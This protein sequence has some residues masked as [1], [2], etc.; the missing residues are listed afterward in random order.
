MKDD[1]VYYVSEHRRSIQHQE[2]NDII[3]EDPDFT[4]F[5]IFI[6]R[7]IRRLGLFLKNKVIKLI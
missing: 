5:P 4:L 2:L 1:D 6:T 7:F 3:V